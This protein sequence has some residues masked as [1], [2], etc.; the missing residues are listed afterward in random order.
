MAQEEK[1]GCGF[2]KVGGLYLCGG[3][4]SVPCDRLPYPLGACPTCGGGIK[5]S[6]GFTKI[7][8]LRLFGPHDCCTDCWRPCFMCDPSAEVAFIMSVGKQYY[9]TP[10]NFLEEADRLGVSKRIPWIPKELELGKTI[11][12]LA[13]PKAY[14]VREPV[15]LQ[16][17]MSIV[18]E[19]ESQAERLLEA[20]KVEY[21]LGIFTVFIPKR[22]E[23]LIWE[24]DATAEECERLKKRD[25]TPIVIK[26]GDLDH[27]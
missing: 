5:A 21:A 18:S 6:R 3:Y 11:I 25:I 4:I 12:Y 7:D 17:A 9:K 13:H 16:R 2:R 14:Q 8:P 26:N 15:V 19:G 10:L 20:E 1:R 23:K 27:A 24:R 22:V